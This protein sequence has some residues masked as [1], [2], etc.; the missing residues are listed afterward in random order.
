MCQKAKKKSLK[1]G[2]IREKCV[3]MRNLFP[4]PGTQN[5][6]ETPS[7]L[8]FFSKNLRGKANPSKYINFSMLWFLSP[9]IS[10]P[11]IGERRRTKW[12]EWRAIL[13]QNKRIGESGLQR[14]NTPPPRVAGL[15][16]GLGSRRSRHEPSERNGSSPFTTPP[17]CW[18]PGFSQLRWWSRRLLFKEKVNEARNMHKTHGCC[19]SAGVPQYILPI[20]YEGNTSPQVVFFEKLPVCFPKCLQQ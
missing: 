8:E 10:W 18:R 15:G 19:L 12:E 5:L 7:G 20:I 6:C 17:M 14:A 11:E 3:K 1:I 4:P 9:K 16:I 2:K 13:K